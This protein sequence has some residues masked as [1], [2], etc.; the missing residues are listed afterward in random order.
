LS[1]RYWLS[2]CRIL[3]GSAVIEILSQSRVKEPRGRLDLA[4]RHYRLTF[5]ASRRTRYTILSPAHVMT[6]REARFTSP[7]TLLMV[8][9]LG[10]E[11]GGGVFSLCMEK[12]LLE[13]RSDS[14]SQCSVIS[15]FT[16]DYP[17]LSVSALCEW[18]DVTNFWICVLTVIMIRRW[19]NVSIYVIYKGKEDQQYTNI[20]SIAQKYWTTLWTLQQYREM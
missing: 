5:W 2:V 15:V 14:R 11:G 1:G 8:S 17:I 18:S 4:P 3:I 9:C 20:E 12:T 7:L 6:P 19:I 10:K 16:V 13:L